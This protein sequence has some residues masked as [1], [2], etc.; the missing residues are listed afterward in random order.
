MQAAEFETI[1]RLPSKE[2]PGG[3]NT[4]AHYYVGSKVKQDPLPGFPGLTYSISDHQGYSGI[5]VWDPLT[6]P[7]KP[8]QKPHEAPNI[9]QY[10]LEKWETD[11]VNGHL[12]GILTVDPVFNLPIPE[13]VSVSDVTVD[14]NYRS[15]GIAKAMYNI[16]FSVMRKT[17]VAGDVQT[18]GGR[19]NWVGLS[20]LP[21]IEVKGYL[22][23]D[24]RFLTPARENFIKRQ[25]WKFI[26]N[27][28]TGRIKYFSFDISPN[29]KGTE[30]SSNTGSKLTKLY[31]N[32]QVEGIYTGIYAYSVANKPLDNPPQ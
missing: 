15:K 18:L 2:H 26:N 25:G 3:R 20:K 24:Y 5:R 12:V 7:T 28:K 13:A 11:K 32:P 27:S 22:G 1:D 21:G 6:E 31:G 4:L 17:L 30:L 10:R 9:Y 16:V 19:R 29:P 8:K 23:I 14:E